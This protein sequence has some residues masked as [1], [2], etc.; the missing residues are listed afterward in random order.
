M[1]KDV[2]SVIL[3]SLAAVGVKH[4][5]GIPGDA[6]NGL[7]DAIRRQDAIRFVPVRHEEAGAFAAS[8]QAKLTDTL[9]VVVGTAGPGAVHLLNG[10][11]DAK[12]DRA[13]VLAITGQVESALLGSYAHQEIDLHSLFDDVSCFSETIV[14]PRQMPGVIRDAIR[15]AISNRGVAHIVLPSDLALEDVPDEDESP[16]LASGGISRPSESDMNSAVEV[17]NSARS[18]VLL[19]GFGAREAVQEVL[20]VSDIL[21]APIVK[22]LRA[23]HLIPDDH[24]NVLGGLGL[25]GTTPAVDA[26]ESADVL[27][28]I[29]TDFPYE[30]FLPDEAHTIQLDSNR[31]VI[32]RRT[33]VEVG[34]VGDAAV[35]LAALIPLLAGNP[36]D[37]HLEEARKNM[38]GWRDEMHD[39]ASDLE[40]PIRP[41]SVAASIAEHSPPG[42]V[43]ICDTGAVTVWAA[44]HL[45]MKEG[46]MFTLSGGLASMAFG[47]AGAI[48]AQLSFPDRKVVALVGDGSFS[49]LLGDLLTAVNSRLPIT[50]VV[51]NNSRLGLIKME[52]EAEGLPEFATEL[53]N[54][55]FGA[56]A[57]A[58]GA[59]G[60]RVEEPSDLSTAIAEALAHDGPAVVDVVV[61]PDEITMPPKIEARFALGYATAKIKEVLGLGSGPGGLKPLE[62]IASRTVESLTD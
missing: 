29:G 13:P 23:K 24:S 1:A 48:G 26:L 40:K 45:D 15:A 8:A 16:I 34:L 4:V 9:G 46:D 36:N 57:T 58:M 6:I 61:N 31:G 37:E 3:E 47:M 21:K 11:Y 56:V 42:T 55:D 43:Y 19:V 17:L 22:T 33:T 59:R 52:Q 10:L 27:F 18:P 60:W 49:M 44:R 35:T 39:I 51:F 30:D 25:L 38:A 7:V 20:E 14:D 41:Q 28:M 32:G 62:E 2:S 12:L 50:V 5:F 54:P 53:E